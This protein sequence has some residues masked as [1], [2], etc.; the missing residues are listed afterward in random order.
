MSRG[1][2]EGFLA[3]CTDDTHWEFVGDQTLDGK[4]AVRRYM[5]ETYTRPPTFDVVR[6]GS[7]PPT[8]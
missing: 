2:Y 4:E 1:D 3:F 5:A 7:S 6:P 8:A